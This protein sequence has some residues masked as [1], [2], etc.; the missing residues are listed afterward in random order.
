MFLQEELLDDLDLQPFAFGSEARGDVDKRFDDILALLQLGATLVGLGFALGL[1]GRREVR[2]V[3]V[4]LAGVIGRRASFAR[5]ARL[6]SLAGLAL[7]AFRTGLTGFAP[8]AGLALRTRGVGEAEFG[9]HLLELVEQ[10]ADFLVC[11]GCEGA[12]C[13][14][15]QGEGLA[16][17]GLR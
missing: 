5:G 4:I 11:F 16:R 17:V 15:E 13:L 3:A 12:Q 14:G 1:L 8:G 10:G 6:A 2:A 7:G 9:Q